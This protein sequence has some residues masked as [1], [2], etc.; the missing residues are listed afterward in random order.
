MIKDS[1]KGYKRHQIK[2]SVHKPLHVQHIRGQY[3][4]FKCSAILLLKKIIE[5]KND[6]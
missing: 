6:Y 5:Y 2:D 3:A 4:S 1:I